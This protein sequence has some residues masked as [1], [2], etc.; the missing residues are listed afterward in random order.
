[1]NIKYNKMAT[2]AAVIIASAALTNLAKA[3]TVLIEFGTDV[4]IPSEAARA[5]IYE[6][7]SYTFSSG[8]DPWAILPGVETTEASEIYYT[9]PGN[10]TTLTIQH[11]DG[12]AFNLLS[13]AV[14]TN[15]STGT[16]VFE[17]LLSSGQTVTKTFENIQPGWDEN[18][19][20][21]P[22]IAVDLYDVTSVTYTGNVDNGVGIDNITLEA[23]VPEPSS[24]LLLGL[25]VLGFATRRKRTN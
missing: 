2:L 20:V 8:G 13:A 11:S 24:A 4:Y 22:V 17:A 3:T 15:G 16:V 18:N 5:E 23:A 19:P 6:E 9:F 10:T 21:P 12:N 25:G 1:M 14:G 7:S